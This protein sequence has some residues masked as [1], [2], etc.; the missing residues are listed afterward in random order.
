[1][2]ELSQIQNVLEDNCK[3]VAI[4]DNAIDE[5]EKTYGEYLFSPNMF[6]EQT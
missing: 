3:E 1:M 2:Y 4:L 5:I 6:S